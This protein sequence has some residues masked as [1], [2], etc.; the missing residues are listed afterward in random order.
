M[1]AWTLYIVPKCFYNIHETK[2][3]NS[4][5]YRLQLENNPKKHSNAAY[6]CIY[7]F[8]TYMVAQWKKGKKFN[9]ELY[10]KMEIPVAASR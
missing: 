1:H 8:C 10:N 5:C 4:Q 6:T 2:K 3:F 7:S 9:P